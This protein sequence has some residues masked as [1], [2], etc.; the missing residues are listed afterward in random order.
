MNTHDTAT[1]PWSTAAFGGQADTSPMELAA[2]ED[3]LALC[4][5]ENRHLSDFRL[6]AESMNGFVSTRFVSSLLLLVFAVVGV[7]MFV[8]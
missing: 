8:L 3:H 7:G 5:G 1:P 4:Q 2:L 6:A